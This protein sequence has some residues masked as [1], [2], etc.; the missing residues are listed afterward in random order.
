MSAESW[1]PRMPDLEGATHRMVDVGEL[2]LHVAEL[3]PADAPPLL[4]VHGWPQNWWCWHKV[5]PELAGDF[6]VLMPDLRGHGWSDAP[7][8]GY[9]KEQFARDL[10]ALLDAL[11]IERA[12]YVGHDWGAF[13]GFLANFAAP[14]RWS[15]FLGLAIPHPWPSR[16]DRLNPWRLAGLGYQLPLATFGRAITQRNLT[17]RVLKA[18]SAGE[19]FTARDIAIYE[20]TMGSERGGRTTVA[21]YR[22]FLT[23]ELLP[24]ARGRYD[25]A[26]LDIPAR[27]VIGNDD[28]IV[29]GADLLGY[30]GNAPNF[31]I[32]RLE[33]ARHF[34]PEERP[35]VVVERARALFS[36]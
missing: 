3:G 24:I 28:L 8:T 4:L 23:R 10:V 9:E 1:T 7:A 12:G 14:E 5:A 16:H 26:R 17:T 13:S 2:S 36:S 20:S 19:P 32:E 30:E 31:E 25:D 15:A 35:E 21:V 34:I 6:R 18:A 33:G 27:L 22:T 29:R 11:E